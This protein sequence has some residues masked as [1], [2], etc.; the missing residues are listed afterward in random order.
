MRILAVDISLIFSM[1][2]EANEGREDSIAFD[3]T[4]ANVTSA[5]QGF[6]RT[7]LAIDS[8]ASFRKVAPEYKA[9][10]KPRDAAYHDQLRRVIERL[11]ADG[12]VP[13]VAPQVGTFPVSGNPSFAEADDVMGWVAEEYSKIVG[14]LSEE[15]ASEWLLAILSDDSD[16]EQLVDD[17]ANIVVIKSALRGG[18]KWDEAKVLERRG[19]PPEKIRDIKALA[20]DKSDN[21]KGY[22]G[23]QKERDPKKPDEDPGLNPGVG[24]GNAVA[25]IKQY[26][27]ALEIFDLKVP[28]LAAQWEAD[29]IKPGICATLARHGR[30]VA[31]KGLF[32]ATIL[33][34]LPGLDFAAVLAEPVVKPIATGPV[35]DLSAPPSVELAAPVESAPEQVT[36]PVVSAPAPIVPHVEAPAEP[37]SAALAVAGPSALSID[38]SS[39]D[40][41]L[42][43]QPRSASEAMAMARFLFNSRLYSKL[44]TPEAVWAIILTGRERG[45]SAMISLTSIFIVEGKPEMSADLIVAQVLRSGKARKFTCVETTD[46]RAVYLV[47]RFDDDAPMR[48]EFTKAHAQARELW[49][50]GNWRKMPDVMLAHRCATKAARLKFPDVTVGLYG[51]G[52]VRERA[53]VDAEFE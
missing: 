12:C 20:G 28:D 13:V 11:T 49:G 43:L 19:V 23:P 3:R 34:E 53:V 41:A 47:Q 29:G 32:L 5:R 17:R 40:W 35:A 30:A 7:M 22:T 6:D 50:K 16:M 9:N 42:S 33:R 27:G 10:R 51:E 37:Q 25:L 44:G 2:R 39:A 46:E 4:I 1:M 21:Y 8:G 36:P 24:E 14:P 18:E 52:E 31:E 45:I 38:P 15:A 26:G 48:V